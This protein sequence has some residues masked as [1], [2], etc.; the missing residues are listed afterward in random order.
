MRRYVSSEEGHLDSEVFGVL[1]GERSP[2]P[3]LIGR[4]NA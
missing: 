3:D 4:V 1:E 2:R